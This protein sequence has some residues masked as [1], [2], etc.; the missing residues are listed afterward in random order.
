MDISL[1]IPSFISSAA[2]ILSGVVLYL[3]KKRDEEIKNLR[4]KEDNLEESGREQSIK[5]TRLE[6]KLW[7]EEK[8]TKTVETAVETV[9]LRFK[10]ELFEK[11]AI[12]AVEDKGG[13][14]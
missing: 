3:L 14:L 6:Q 10:L 7:S 11:G 5:I 12:K 2:G 8:L 4:E 13:N 1:I 9:F